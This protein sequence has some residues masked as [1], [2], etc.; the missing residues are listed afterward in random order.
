MK[1][2]F[3][4]CF[5]L[6]TLLLLFPCGQRESFS[7]ENEA[8]KRHVYAIQ[9]RVFHCYHEIGASLGYFPDDF[10]RLYPIGLHYTFHLND[11]L[12]WEVARG[13]LMINQE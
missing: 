2:R 5:S 10:Y 6:L 9:N 7:E 8:D 12:A 13:Y 3:I 4:L 11:Y 1:K